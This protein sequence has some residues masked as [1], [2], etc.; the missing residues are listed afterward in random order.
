M[1]SVSFCFFAGDIACELSRHA[2]KVFLAT[3]HAGYTIGR[4]FFGGVPFDV[5]FMKRATNFLIPGFIKKLVV[6]KMCDGIFNHANF[7]LEALKDSP[8]GPDF[9]AVNDEIFTRISTGHVT[10]TPE[11]DVIQGKKV[12]FSNGTSAVDTDAIILATGYKRHFPFVKDEKLLGIPVD[13][14]GFALYKY[15]FPPKHGGRVAIVGAT[16]VKGSVLPVFELQ[17]RFVA[18]VFCGSLKLPTANE[19]VKS[20]EEKARYWSKISKDVRETLKVNHK[21]FTSFFLTF[22]LLSVFLYFLSLEPVVTW[23]PYTVLLSR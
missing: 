9:A 3:K 18:E 17:S 2:S 7:G 12:I 19:M 21:C 23:L 16:G 22:F 14:K 1:M 13:G 4:I 5:K 6:P 10:I 15:I 11:I 20:L 8:M